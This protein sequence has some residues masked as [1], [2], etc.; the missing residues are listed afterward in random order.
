MVHPDITSSN[1]LLNS[2]LEACVSDFGTTKLLDP[3]S[4]NQ[5]CVV[6]TYGYIV[7]GECH[8]LLQNHKYF[9]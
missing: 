8:F 9:L 4:S 3:D 6:G 7:P 2:Q 1:V 5:T